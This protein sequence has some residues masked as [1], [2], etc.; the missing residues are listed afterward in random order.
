[1]AACHSQWQTHHCFSTRPSASGMAVLISL[2]LPQFNTLK[3]LADTTTARRLCR[4]QTFATHQLAAMHFLLFAVNAETPRKPLVLQI[5]VD[6]FDRTE[7]SHDVC[8]FDRLDLFAEVADPAI[9]CFRFGCHVLSHT[10]GFVIHK[11]ICVSRTIRSESTSAAHSP[12][13]SGTNP[14]ANHVAGFHHLNS[15]YLTST[16]RHSITRRRSPHLGHGP[17]AQNCES[18]RHGSPASLHFSH[19]A[20]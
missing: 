12:L 17:L 13:N 11:L 18:L 5:P 9:R 3:R 8:E 19:T 15:R 2:Q 10:K 20:R 14:T 16:A 6:A 7:S 4:P 1:M